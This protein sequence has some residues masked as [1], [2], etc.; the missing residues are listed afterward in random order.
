VLK[1]LR[2]TFV[3]T[4]H[5]Y[6]TRLEYVTANDTRAVAVYRARG[7]RNGRELDIDQALF[8]LIR[9]G[10]IVDVTAIPFDFAAFNTFWA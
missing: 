4:E 8:C 5:T 1:F 9:D 7:T 6:N 3:L 2:N 10:E